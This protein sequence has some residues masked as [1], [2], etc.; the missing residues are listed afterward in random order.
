LKTPYGFFKRR[1]VA[2]FLVTL[3]FF[4]ILLYLWLQ[5]GAVGSSSE[6]RVVAGCGMVV[7]LDSFLGAGYLAGIFLYSSTML[8]RLGFFPRWIESFFI[9][10]F[11]GFAVSGIFGVMGGVTANLAYL[12]LALGFLLY[13]SVVVVSNLYRFHRL[14]SAPRKESVAFSPGPKS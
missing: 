9:A 11:V 14:L 1:Y 5:F 6:G 13:A 10:P 4:E 7:Q 3:S 12:G 2:G 8:G